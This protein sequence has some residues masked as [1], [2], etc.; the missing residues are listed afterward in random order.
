MT[1]K[2]KL[3]IIGSS[4]IASGIALYFILNKGKQEDMGL[5]PNGNETDPNS[6]SNEAQENESINT[7]GNDPIQEGDIIYPF[8]EYANLRTSMEVD[9]GWFGNM[10]T[11]GDMNGRVYS[12]SAIGK[13]CEINYVAG[14]TWY[15][16]DVG[17]L[18]TN[19]DLCGSG[20]FGCSWANEYILTPETI[21][22]W[23]AQDTHTP[24]NLTAYVRADVVTK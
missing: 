2:T 17:P 6:Q 14:H 19:D 23:E 20:A 16:V 10:F 11:W 8:G 13:V 24:C 5:T 3:I 15:K 21:N 4:L 9:N 1:K 12:P 22:F 18:L 7:E